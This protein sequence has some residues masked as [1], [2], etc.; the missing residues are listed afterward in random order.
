MRPLLIDR[1]AALEQDE[2]VG[3]AVEVDVLDGTHVLV[4][5]GLELL[6]EID[7]VVEVAIRLAPYEF[8]TFVILEHVGAAV[9]VGVDGDLNELALAIVRTPDIRASIAVQIL[10]A[11]RPGR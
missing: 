5:R 4:R 3:R 8:A 10:G 1:S 6:D 7:T 11:N 2:Q 9:E